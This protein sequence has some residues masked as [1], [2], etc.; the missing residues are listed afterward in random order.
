MK[1]GTSLLTSGTLVLRHSTIQQ[2]SVSSKQ[3][4]P[5]SLCS[6]IFGCFRYSL[7]LWQ[8]VYGP[9]LSTIQYLPGFGIVQLELL[10]KHARVTALPALLAC[11]LTKGLFT[12]TVSTMIAC[13]TATDPHAAPVALATDAIR[14]TVISVIFMLSPNRYYALGEQDSRPAHYA[15]E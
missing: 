14:T 11:R 12:D 1:S 2:P 8:S 3:Y 10:K 13:S 5:T 7:T 4:T 6:A 9:L 15:R